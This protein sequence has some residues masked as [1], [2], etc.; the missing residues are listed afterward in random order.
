MIE[1]PEQEV[2]TGAKGCSHGVIA[3]AIFLSQQM[4]LQDSM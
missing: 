3:T 1:Q 4:D 2:P